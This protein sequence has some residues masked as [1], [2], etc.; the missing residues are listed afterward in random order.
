MGSERLEAASAS[1]RYHA[2]RASQACHKTE[3]LVIWVSVR[4]V[5]GVD[6]LS[7]NSRRR[8]PSSKVIHECSSMTGIQVSSVARG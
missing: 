7:G 5:P 1:Y 3:F 4:F 8:S 2:A 6:A